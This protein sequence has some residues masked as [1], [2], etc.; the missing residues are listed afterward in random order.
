M[1]KELKDDDSYLKYLIYGI[2]LFFVIIAVGILRGIY[3]EKQIEK[4]ENSLKNEVVIE[5]R[6]ENDKKSNYNA[7][8]LYNCI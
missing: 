2:I 6:I 3:N 8:S 7:S 5:G 4:S 1:N